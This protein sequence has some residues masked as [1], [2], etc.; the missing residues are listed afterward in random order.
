MVLGDV[1]SLFLDP[2]LDVFVFF[3][4]FLSVSFAFVVASTNTN[5]F[6]KTWGLVGFGQRS[7]SYVDL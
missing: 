7:L 1:C 6:L 5:N 4:S 3:V 2:C